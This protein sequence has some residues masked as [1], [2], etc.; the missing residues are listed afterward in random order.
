MSSRN[1]SRE[2]LRGL[3][4]L[5]DDEWITIIS[6]LAK[7]TTVDAKTIRKRLLRDTRQGRLVRMVSLLSKGP[8]RLHQIMQQLG[9]SRRTVFRDL[10][11]LESL[12]VGLEL[13]PQNEYRVTS[14][15][16]VLSQLA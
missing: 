7:E 10:N 14:E 6:A 5:R 8:L 3:V 11:D 1:R 16:G 12:G 4:Q 13:S 15:S 9:V 2:N